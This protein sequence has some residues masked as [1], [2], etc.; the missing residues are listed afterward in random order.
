[1]S[2]VPDC[3]AWW[4]DY[5]DVQGSGAFDGPSL[6]TMGDGGRRWL[7]EM[8]GIRF[9]IKTRQGLAHWDEVFS[10]DVAEVT[11]VVGEIDARLAQL[12]KTKEA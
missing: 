10:A 7:A 2:V 4:R 3:L 1:M 9:A 6:R 12:I 5:R 8:A 11:R